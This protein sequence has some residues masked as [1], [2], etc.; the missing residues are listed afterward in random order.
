MTTDQLRVGRRVLRSGGGE[1]FEVDLESVTPR[2]YSRVGRGR[3]ADGRA[4]FCKQFV[5]A[6]GRRMSAT[7]EGE[8]G[9]AE[10]AALAMPSS[11]IE[12][13]LAHDPSDL[14]L[15][16]PW[17]DVVPLDELLRTD[18]TGLEQLWP[19]VLRFVDACLAEAEAFDVSTGPALKRKRCEGAERTGLVFKGF[20]VRN[21]GLDRASGQLCFFDTGPAYVGPSEEAVARLL[22]SVWLLNWGRPLGRFVAGPPAALAEQTAAGLS[23]SAGA[24]ALR[25]E[26]DL[27]ARSRIADIPAANPAVRLGKRLVFATIGRRYVSTLRGWADLYGR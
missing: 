1:A 21:L 19:E 7:Y 13:P 27:Q 11:N 24:A 4:V 9:G 18:P 16:Y 8:A 22:V 10:L 5:S 17:R 2:Y 6:D 15:A 26:I 25:R 3:L 12:V 20:E 14:V 23:R